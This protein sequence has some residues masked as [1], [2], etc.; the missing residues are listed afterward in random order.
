[1]SLGE[2]GPLSR[3]IARLSEEKRVRLVTA[4][5]LAGILLIL[6][7]QLL[8]DRA[9]APAA[10]PPAQDEAKALEE[11]L[12]AILSQVRGVGRVSVLV[13][14]E[15]G[16]RTE[17]AVNAQQ[18]ES[19][20]EGGGDR[21]EETV[22]SQRSYLLIDGASGKQPLALSREGARIRGV[23]VVCEGGRDAVVKTRVTEAVTTALGVASNRVC[24]LQSEH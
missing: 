7:G 20:T 2:N 14:L 24:V 17:Y 16:E 18:S 9:S 1:M 5:G 19:R 8:G 10:Q 4:V 13:T 11:R 22:S 3:L 6:A 12:C 21:R 23:V 15:T